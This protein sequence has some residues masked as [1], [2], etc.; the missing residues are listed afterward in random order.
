MSTPIPP[1]RQYMTE[2]PHTVGAEQT[3]AH[4]HT[5]LYEKR[6]RHLPVLRGGQLVGLL[7]ERDVALVTSLKDVDANTITVEEA[8]SLAIYKVPPD[9]PLD[10]VCSEMAAKRLGSAI[11]VEHGHVVGILTTVD[12]CSALAEL[13]QS[14]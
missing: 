10:K 7:S 5:V 6:I 11:V 4:A 14:R 3:L 13:L 12:V 2:S 1:V 8:M 9:A